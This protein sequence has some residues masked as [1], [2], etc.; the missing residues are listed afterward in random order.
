MPVLQFNGVY[1]G[2]SPDA[3]YILI[4]ENGKETESTDAAIYEDFYSEFQTAE[5]IEFNVVTK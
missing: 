5:V 4:D 2:S 3:K 1:Y